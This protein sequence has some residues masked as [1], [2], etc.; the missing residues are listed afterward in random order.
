[1]VTGLAVA[2]VLGEVPLNLA[3]DIVNR[4]IEKALGIGPVLALERFSE[5]PEDVRRAK[6]QS[7]ELATIDQVAAPLFEVEFRHVGSSAAPPFQLG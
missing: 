4:L 2:F 1:M 6:Q 3:L 7:L 5:A